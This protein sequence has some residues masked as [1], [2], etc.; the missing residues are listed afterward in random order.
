MPPRKRRLSYRIKRRKDMGEVKSLD[1]CVEGE[2]IPNE[3]R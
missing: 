2:I 3:A 1:G